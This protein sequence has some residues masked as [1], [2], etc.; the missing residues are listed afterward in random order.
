MPILEVLLPAA[1]VDS[2]IE[3]TAASVVGK[4]P[5]LINRDPEPAETGVAKA[6][7]IQLDI[8]TVDATG[9]IDLAATQVYVDGVLAFSAGTFQAGF[10]GP[11]SAY[12]NPVADVLRITIDPTI[13]AFASEEVIDV[14]VVSQAVG[15]PNVLDET[16]QFIIEDYAAPKL[17]SAVA[18][19]LQRVR[20]TFDEDVVEIDTTSLASALRAGNYTLERL[21]DYLTPLVSA[22]IVSAEAV[23]TTQVDV[24]TDIPLT[25]GGYYKITG[26]NLED[27]DGNAILAP[28]DFAYFWG[29]QPPVPE[30][31]DFDLYRKLPLINR[32]EDTSQDLYRFIACL[33]E[34]TGLLLYDID[35]FI[36][37]LDPDTAPE[38]W[39]DAMLADLGNPFAF[40]LEL[41]DKRRLAQI[42]VD[43]YR[44]KG[45]RV[46][47]INVIRFFM[48]LEVTIDEFN[49]SS[50]TWILGDSELGFNTYLG[51][52][53]SSILY[54][55]TVTSVVALTDA[56]RKQ[57]TEIVEY[58]KPAHTH[59]VELIEPEIPEILD[60]LEL[61]LSELGENWFLH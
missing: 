1:Y 61:G 7:N 46:G 18:Q 2:V 24:Y 14:R 56:Q 57:L 45:T 20:L 49:L 17:L 39:L 10:T 6:T 19:D 60:H 55:F 5:T 13:S 9:S 22:S 37:I 15:D 54:S 3:D 52:S 36:E 4:T 59:F 44:S 58:M 40:E 30:G 33:Q 28:D 48:G 32:Q 16:Y 8:A 42:L 35:K 12:S 38:D 31:R 47:I 11:A 34:V 26:A 50:G 29:W 43:I 51:S 25:P 27:T 53:L 23:T 21:G 41:E